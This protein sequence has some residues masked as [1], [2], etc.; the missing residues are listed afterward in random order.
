MVETTDHASSGE[1]GEDVLQ[2]VVGLA[3]RGGVIHGEQNAGDHLGEKREHRNAAEDLVPTA[4]ARDLFV[5]EVADERLEAGPLLHPVDDA[6]YHASD[7]LTEPRR[8]LVPSTLTSY[9]S[10]GRGAGPVSTLPV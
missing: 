6:A 3:G 9:L 4:G 5:E 2:A 1:F 8:S 10:R 7:L